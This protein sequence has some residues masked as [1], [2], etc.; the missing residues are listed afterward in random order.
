MKM[1]KVRMSVLAIVLSATNL[2]SALAAIALD[3][4]RVVFDGSNNSISLGI[5]NENKSSPYLAQGWL[6]DANGNKINGP[7]TVLPP[8]QRVEPGSK[9]Q[10]KI[11]GLPNIS[12]L[13]Q[14]RETLFY[15]NLREIPPRSE[16][17]NTMQLAL[18]SRIKVF[19]RPKPIV[20]T[21]AQMSTPWQNKLTLTKVGDKVHVNNPTPYFVTLIDAKPSEKAKSAGNFQAVMLEPMG[22]DTLDISASELGNAPVLTY[23]NDYGGR[24]QL[25]F[26]CSGNTC[27]VDST[28]NSVRN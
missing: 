4:T 6:E 10:V 2:P 26:K 1:L 12:S 11:Q 27:E 21:K 19:Y 24:P 25:Y 18:Q 23:I 8:V 28:R 20:L 16:K 14:D 22:K 3:R 13:P 17:P 7:L 9:S 15:F 5:A